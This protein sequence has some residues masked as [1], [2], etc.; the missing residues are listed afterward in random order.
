MELKGEPYLLL[1]HLGVI[2][3]DQ[4][5]KYNDR[6]RDSDSIAVYKCLKSGVIFLDDTEL[7]QVSEYEKKIGFN[8]W[9]RQWNRHKKFV[10]EK[11]NLSADDERRALQ[12]KWNIKN[13]KWLDFGTGLGGVLRLL[14]DYSLIAEGL[15]PQ[16]APREFLIES[17]IEC[18]A[19][20]NELEDGKYDVIILFH[21]LEHLPD[22]VG[23]LEVLKQKLSSG[24]SIIIEIPH[25]KDALLELYESDSFKQ[26]TLWSEHLILHT[27]ESL[28]K[29]IRAAGFSDFRITGFQRYTL[30]N[31]LHWLAKN[32]PSGHVEWGQMNG[33]MIHEAYE[34]VLT[35][36]DMTDTLIATI[37]NQKKA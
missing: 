37:S 18:Y 24:G 6:V 4:V 21:V 33:D 28:S 34:S 23:I 7:S 2:D 17:G 30:Y 35:K 10:P 26:F 11:A 13:K 3:P 5:V 12:F 15:E 9:D 16:E 25:A 31:H 29:V 1:R 14:K 22:P 27:R 36:M 19:D 8:Y 20:L 32:K